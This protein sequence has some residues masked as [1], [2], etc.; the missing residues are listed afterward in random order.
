MEIDN[1]ECDLVKADG[2]KVSISWGFG[3]IR[4]DKRKVIGLMGV[5][6]DLTERREMELKLLQTERLA[7]LGQLS[8]GVAHEINNPLGVI[9][10]S[11]DTLLG[12]ERKDQFK[13]KNLKRIKAQVE[14]SARIVDNLL[15]FSRPKK[16]DIQP[17]KIN[18]VLEESLSLI[19]HQL[20][21][22]NVEVVREFNA[23]LPKIKGDRNQLQQVFMN[24][25]QNAHKAMPDG[26][27]LYIVTKPDDGSESFIQIIFS[28]LGV[29]IAQRDIPHIFDPFYTTRE[30]GEGTGLGLSVSY[31]II[32]RH[33]GSIRVES[34]P[35]KKTAFFIRL[36]VCK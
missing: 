3:G 24:M 22:D 21:L 2:S 11:V 23:D 28:D 35:G 7:S 18:E 36:P 8:A 19:E 32:E 6:R 17:L 25:I 5:G 34:T 26:G 14:R 27:K 20:Q 33:N 31:S 9:A 16:P 1:Y 4:N 12:R 30:I 15:N 29:G 13:I 10:T